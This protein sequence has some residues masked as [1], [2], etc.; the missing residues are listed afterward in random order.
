M[1]FLHV[2][3]HIFRPA[4]EEAGFEFTSP[5]TMSAE[6]VQAEIIGN[7]EKADLVLCDISTWNPNVFF[8]LDIRVA[9]DKPVA[10]VRDQ[11][12]DRVPFDNSMINP[13]RYDGCLDIHRVMATVPGLAAF[14]N[15]AKA[16]EQNALWKYFGITQR[17]ARSD[18]E[19]LTDSTVTPPRT[20]TTGPAP[21]TVHQEVHEFLVDQSVFTQK[22]D[23]EHVDVQLASAG[24]LV[25]SIFLKRGLLNSR[26]SGWPT[27]SSSSR[28]T[29]V[30]TARTRR[31]SSTPCARDMF[32]SDSPRTAA[33]R[34]RL[35]PGARGALGEGGEA[36]GRDTSGHSWSVS[37]VLGDSP[38]RADDSGEAPCR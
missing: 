36:F 21:R 25:V 11:H 31:S 17:A 12:A 33:V 6:I 2:A 13:Y 34:A 4:A 30:T 9:L 27:A 37:A 23:G 19:S 24:G 32:P 15:R 38:Q 20:T 7:L 10:M 16:Q 3:E 8:E 26:R 22:N 18:P 5:R 14:L 35:E 29:T 28:V 1:H